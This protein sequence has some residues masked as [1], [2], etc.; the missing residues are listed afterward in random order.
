MVD[1]YLVDQHPTISK[2]EP[3]IKGH[4]YQNMGASD[5]VAVS[6]G[7]TTNQILKGADWSSEYDFP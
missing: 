4:P 1:G 5:S 2:N 7:V 6:A 3:L